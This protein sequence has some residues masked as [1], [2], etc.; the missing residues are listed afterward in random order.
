MTNQAMIDALNKAVSLEYAA[1]IQYLQHSVLIQGTDREVYSNFF[2]EMGEGA[3]RHARELGSY[4]VGMNGVPTVEP[5]AVRQST[6]LNE[7]LQQDLEL[8][9]ISLRAYQSALAVVSDDVPT[10]VMLE[11]IIHEEYLHVV[12]LEKMLGKKT[13]QIASKEVKR[14]QT[15]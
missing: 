7:M 2:K 9:Q 1:A 13:L 4:I 11:E 15:G 8:E 3:Y 10:R 12:R 6:D 5:G 14:K